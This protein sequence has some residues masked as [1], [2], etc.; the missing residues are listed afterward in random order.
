V[1]DVLTEA[2]A[3]LEAARSAIRSTHGGRLSG[4]FSARAAAERAR[5][6]SLFDRASED[7]RRARRDARERESV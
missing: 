2:Y 4:D 6:W 7:V 5:L 3:R 1:N